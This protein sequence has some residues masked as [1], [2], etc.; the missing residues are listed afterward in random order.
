MIIFVTM[1]II[2]LAITQDL[3]LKN[4]LAMKSI[5]QERGTNRKCTNACW[6][7]RECCE[8]CAAVSILFAITMM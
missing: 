7:L 2:L 5:L 8:F 4:R 1:S 3:L 6:W